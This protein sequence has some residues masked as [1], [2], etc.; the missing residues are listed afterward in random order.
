MKQY[1][2]LCSLEQAIEILA[3][4]HQKRWTNKGQPGRFS[5]QKALAITKQTARYFA[6][7]DWLRLYFLT[8]ENKVV[9]IELNL[10]YGGTMYCHLKGFDPDYSKYSVGNLL[11]LKVLKECIDRKISEYDFMQ[12][13]E[14]YTQWTSKYRRNT[15][16]KWVNKSFSSLLINICLKV[17]GRAKICSI[18]SKF[19]SILHQFGAIR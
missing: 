10:E 18:L 9:A 1:Y 6:E 14:A 19:I 17:A 13:D 12:R 7:K 4:L 11:T 15:D 2:E 5:N 8:V 3:R 16:V